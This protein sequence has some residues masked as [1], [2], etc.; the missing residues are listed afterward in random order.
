MLS[1]LQLATPNHVTKPQYKSMTARACV[2]A[3]LIEDRPCV[4]LL[5]SRSGF[6]VL[7]AVAARNGAIGRVTTLV[8]IRVIDVL[9][10]FR[11]HS[12]ATDLSV[13]T[14]STTGLDF[15]RELLDKGSGEEVVAFFE[16]TSVCG[17]AVTKRKNTL[18]AVIAIMRP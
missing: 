9:F 11:V 6:P 7:H 15:V 12:S 18:E 3:G 4:L 5:I 17:L 1:H 16:N 2:Y 13:S 8:G 14:G 10:L